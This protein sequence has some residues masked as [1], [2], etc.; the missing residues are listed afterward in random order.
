MNLKERLRH[1]ALELGFEDMGFTGSE[2]LDL[3]IEEIES[4]PDMYEWV[5]TDRFNVRRGASPHERYPWAKSILVLIRNYHR[6]RF[7]PQL[8]GKI[9]RCYQ[10]DERKERGVEHQRI[11][12]F[13]ALMKQEGIRFYFDEEIPARM[14]AARAGLVTYGKNC[15]VYARRGMLGASWLE[16]IPILI[17]TEIEPDDPSIELG[18]PSWCKNACLAACPTGA[19]YSPKKMNPFQ[20]IAFNTYYGSGITPADLREPMGTWVYGC[21]RCQEVCPRNQPWMNQDLPENQSLTGRAS[22]FRLDTLLT[23]TQDHYV[24]KVWPLTFYISR[25]NIAKWQ[26]NAARALG[27]LGDRG[28]VPLLTRVMGD[29][30]DE[31]VRGMCAWALGRLGGPQARAALESRLAQEGELGREEIK[32]ALTKIK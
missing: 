30:P 15:F 25:K 11:K 24:N 18:C 19:L 26:M 10:V 13:F 22:D 28:H 6:Q 5:M 8:I 14:S 32:S 17:D 31:T 3:Y 21:D 1:R 2:P 23:M 4:R 9:G 12:D 16:N 27:N 29:H 7:P 20:C